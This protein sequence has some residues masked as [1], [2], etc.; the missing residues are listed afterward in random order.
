MMHGMLAFL[1]KKLKEKP[2]EEFNNQSSYSSNSS[3]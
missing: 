3:F 2:E 1:Q